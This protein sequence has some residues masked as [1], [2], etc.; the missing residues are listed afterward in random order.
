MFRETLKLALQAIRLNPLR[1]FLTVLG[2]VI[3]VGAVIAMVT[4]GSGT[5]AQVTADIAK[6]GTNLLVLRPGQA[7][8]GPGGVREAAPAF[9]LKD[10]SAIEQQ[11]DWVRMLSPTA[12]NNSKSIYCNSNCSTTVIGTDNR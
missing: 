6:L 2:I 8:R 4:I 10:V 7:R 5:T 9:D 3:G 11:I 12:Q 1:S